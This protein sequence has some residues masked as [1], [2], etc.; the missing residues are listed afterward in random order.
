[1]SHRPEPQGGG[2]LTLALGVVVLMAMLAA[3]SWA[4]ALCS[5]AEGGQCGD[6][7]H[8]GRVTIADA[9]IAAAWYAPYEFPGYCCDVWND[10]RVGSVTV[11]DALVI[12]QY[13]VGLGSFSGQCTGH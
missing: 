9:H 12:A 5:Y 8:D 13:V 4:G 7:D 11:L 10:G 2:C 1:M 3:A 6:C